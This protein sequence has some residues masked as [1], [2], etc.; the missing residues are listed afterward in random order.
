M[1]KTELDNIKYC[2]PGKFPSSKFITGLG[3]FEPL[4]VI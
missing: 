1:H 4:S 2:L 3:I